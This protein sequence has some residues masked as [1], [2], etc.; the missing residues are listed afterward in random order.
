MFTASANSA[1]DTSP[2]RDPEP[3]RGARLDPPRRQRPPRRARHARVD[4]ALDVVVDRARAA[5]GEVS[6]DHRR[7]QDHAE[8]GQ[9]SATNIVASGRHEQQRDHARLGQRDVVAD[10]ARARRRAARSARARRGVRR[11]R[12]P[13]GGRRLDAPAVVRRRGATCGTAS[14]AQS[15]TARATPTAAR[16]RSGGRRSAMRARRPTRSRRRAAP[17]SASRPRSA[18]KPRQRGGRVGVE[19][20][21]LRTARANSAS[22]TVTATYMNAR[23][24]RW[25]SSAV[26]RAERQELAAAGRETRRHTPCARRRRACSRPVPCSSLADM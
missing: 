20:P 5:G 26:L 21:A 24:V 25:M 13:S 16:R 10:A 19:A 4:V 15:R 2:E 3:Q 9:E 7:E 6:A 18:A 1:N 8:P 11:R 23:W 12:L 17:G 22:S 14:V